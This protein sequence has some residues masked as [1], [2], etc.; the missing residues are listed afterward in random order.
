MDE[1][2]VTISAAEA[3]LLQEM[4]E[5]TAVNGKD[6]AALAGLYAKANRA[7]KELDAKAG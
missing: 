7:T 5:K 2:T 3:K 4:C 1:A 6:A